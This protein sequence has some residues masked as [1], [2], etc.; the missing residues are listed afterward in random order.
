[1]KTWLFAFQ[2]LFLALWLA[3]CGASLAAC[4][5]PV[6]QSTPALTN[7]GFPALA[8]A[9]ATPDKLYPVEAPLT[10]SEQATVYP[11]PQAP[12]LPLATPDADLQ[13]LPDG[14]ETSYPQPQAT[15]VPVDTV[16]PGPVSTAPVFPELSQT[17]DQPIASGN[18]TDIPA[19][20]IPGVLETATTVASPS[21]T[22]TEFV[23]LPVKPPSSSYL[24]TI[25]ILHSWQEPQILVL[26]E[27]V[28]AF[29]A[30]YPGVTFDV[31]YI[32]TEALLSR[33]ELA[34]YNRGGPMLLLGTAEWGGYLFD[35]GLIENIA[36]YM[37]AEFEQTINPA[38]L[39]ALR[40]R[41]AVTGLPYTV[42]G[43]VL[44]RNKAILADPVTTFDDLLAASTEVTRGG[45]V[46]F[47]FDVGSFFSMAH[48]QGL[49]G[50]W[51]D[52][53]GYPRFDQNDYQYAQQWLDLIQSFHRLGVTEINGV[54]DVILFKAGKAGY[55]IAE[56]SRRGELA[57]AIGP[58]NL[59]IDPWPG[60]AS[61][62]L[63]GYVQSQGVFL[64]SNIR[65]QSGED[66]F[67]SLVFMGLLLTPEIQSR[68]AETGW[69]PSTMTAMPRDTLVRQAV[70]SLATGVA[71]PAA[72]Q[73]DIRSIYFTA[74]DTMIWQVL[75]Q[76][77]DPR[78][79][80][81][82]TFREISS[83]IETVR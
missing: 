51:L 14:N 20:G 28:Q 59:A 47:F 76:G 16:Y 4:Q 50:R 34:A 18:A 10:A 21:P 8:T 25:R 60:L 77:I 30:S 64:N 37:S 12:V 74:L 15:L 33:Y 56:V 73:S 44:Y 7:V 69:I 42:E 49:G 75:D 1:M 31:S 9:L 39:G 70:E 11:V 48:L 6:L 66:H 53:D 58:D 63:A 79:A 29:Q 54:D 41:Q 17:P 26:H 68:L 22:P 5:P 32:P 83:R 27:A 61:G 2:L 43:V 81:E 67:I 45:T 35:R 23:P 82:Q 36:P 71:Y 72:L 3:V 52:E 78:Q 55:I 19:A 46:G 38:A 80:L 57:E 62:Q 24:G 40:H 13:A 65:E